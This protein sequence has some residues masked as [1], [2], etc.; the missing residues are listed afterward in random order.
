MKD[1]EILKRQ[2]GYW[3]IDEDGHSQGAY[4]TVEDAQRDI[5][6][7]ARVQYLLFTEE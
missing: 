4:Q 3:I 2:D 5:P 6:L 7:G 1:Y